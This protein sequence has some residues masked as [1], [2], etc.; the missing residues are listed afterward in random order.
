M[1]ITS[2][3]NNSE[4]L[5]YI[6]NL[7][8]DFSKPQFNH[9]KNLVTGIISIDSKRNIS[10]LSSK[11]LNSKDRSCVT[12]FL[13]NSPWDDKSLD[14]CRIN[15]L[16]SLTKPKAN[17]TIFIVIDDTVITKSKDTKH[18]EA[19]GYHFSHTEGK[20]VWGHCIVSSQI[21]TKSHS[22][23]LGFKQYFS[24]SYCN[25]RNLTFETKLEIANDLVDVFAK[26]NT[27]RQNKIYILTDSWFASKDF[28]EK[29]LSWGYH[30]ISGFR[31][32]RCIYPKGIKVKISDFIKYTSED[33]FKD[34]TIKDKTYKVYR[35]EG[36]AS[37]I[38][39]AVVLICYEANKTNPK[40]VAILSTD[41]ELSSKIILKHYSNRWKIETSFLYLKDRLG[42]K[43]YQMRKIKGFTR[44][45]SIV[46]LA[47]TLLELYRARISQE[48]SKLT[49]G[50][51]IQKFKGATFKSL[52][53]LIYVC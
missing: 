45:W 4:V 8:L 22:V 32:N 16:L 11:V 46:Y 42:L 1:P 21:I 18:I 15:N 43:H 14:A 49:L 48:K 39:N 47:Y 9:L 3:P 10:N 33:D 19:L 25:Q 41:T 40:I 52:I 6:N 5:N 27:Y 34:V 53:T 36:K 17:E 20:S 28:F 50:D 44:F 51:T 29:N 13:N 31:T 24:E 12:K 7:N 37:G 38:D 35:Y 26:A 2:I 30:T 23:P